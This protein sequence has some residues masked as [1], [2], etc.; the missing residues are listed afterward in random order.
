M[1]QKP[2]KIRRNTLALGFVCLFVCLLFFSGSGYQLLVWLV[3]LGRLVVWIPGIPNRWD[4]NQQ[5][6]YSPKPTT[7]SPQNHHLEMR[8]LRYPPMPRFP[9]KIGP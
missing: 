7:G 8:N 6:L 9:Q 4:R 5:L 3:G 2:E 1:E